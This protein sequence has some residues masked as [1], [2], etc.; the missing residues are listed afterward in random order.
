MFNGLKTPVKWVRLP[1]KVTDHGIGTIL[2]IVL[3]FQVDRA[4]LQEEKAN[5]F[6]LEKWNKK[7]EE[8]K[9]KRK[10]ERIIIINDNRVSASQTQRQQQLIKIIYNSYLM[11]IHLLIYFVYSLLKSNTLGLSLYYYYIM[12][13]ILIPYNITLSK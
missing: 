1:K 4:C 8:R 6:F 11:H 13:I 7:K 10:K 3:K 12:Y 5:G 9:E 2:Y